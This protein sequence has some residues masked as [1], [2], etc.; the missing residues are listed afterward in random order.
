M[1][2]GG[3]EHAEPLESRQILLERIVDPPQE[4]VWTAWTDPRQ[5][6]AATTTPW[7]HPM[8][9]P[10]GANSCFA[11]SCHPSDWCI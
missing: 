5:V 4:L 3:A 10:C 9:A 7:Q 2:A 11:R 8:V 1:A 6:M